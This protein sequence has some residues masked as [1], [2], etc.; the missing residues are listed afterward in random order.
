M[1]ERFLHENVYRGASLM[2]SIRQTA[3]TLCGTGAVGSNLAMNLARQGFYSLMLMDHDRIE[4]HNLG[5]Q[6][7]SETEIGLLKAECLRNR[8]FDELGFEVELQTKRLT[9]KNAKKLL[10]E[11]SFIVDSF[12]N[13][14]SRKL[15]KE[16]SLETGVPCLH[17]GLNGDYAEVIWNDNYRVPSDEGQ[18]IC[19]YPLARNLI[20]M[21]VAVASECIIRYIDSEKKA[22]YTITLGDFAIKTF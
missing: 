15:V 4:S 13:S 21:A 12:D 17:V 3:I 8:L 14:E 9:A 5:T 19:D 11:A 10:K 16:Y 20:F 18:D 6:I 7:W 2:K 22:N 1:S